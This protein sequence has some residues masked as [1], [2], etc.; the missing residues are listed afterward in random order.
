MRIFS[1]LNWLHVASTETLTYYMSH[2][3]QGSIA[4]DEI[5]ILPYFEGRAIHD[6]W[7]SYFNYSCE[8]GLCNAHHLRD[9]TEAHAQYE[10]QWAKQM[11]EYL[12]EVKHKRE[13]STGKR[14]AS[15]TIN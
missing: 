8:H 11:I 4:F 12:L 13:N 15:R 1:K 3:K 2:P 5:G 9:L 7:S 14:F 10:Q 6:G